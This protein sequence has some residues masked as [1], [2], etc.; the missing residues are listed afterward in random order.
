MTCQGAQANDW[1]L[2]DSNTH[3]EGHASCDDSAAARLFCPIRGESNS[4][5]TIST[6]QACATVVAQDW[7]EHGY[8]LFGEIRWGPTATCQANESTIEGYR[9]WFV[10]ACGVKLNLVGS[11]GTRQQEWQS[12]MM[13]CCHPSWYSLDLGEI[14]MPEATVGLT[15][16]PY[17][18]GTDLPGPVLPIFRR[19]LTTT[20]T[21]TSFTLTTTTTVSISTSSTT[22]SSSTITTT[23]GAATLDGCWG[24][25]VSD[26]ATAADTPEFQEA[27]RQVLARA[28][29]PDVLPEYVVDL[30]LAAG[31]GCDGRLLSGRRLQQSLRVD[32]LI[33]FPTSLGLEA[34][35]VLAETSQK[36]LETV[37]VE[38]TSAWLNEEVAQVEALQNLEVA[39]A[40]KS[41]ALSLSS[42]AQQL[43]PEN[44]ADG[45]A[46]RLTVGSVA[47]LFPACLLVLSWRCGKR[48]VRN[49]AISQSSDFKLAVEVYPE[50]DIQDIRRSSLMDDEDFRLSG[51]VE[52]TANQD[53]ECPAPAIK[54]KRL[55]PKGR[56]A[57][58]AMAITVLAEGA[59]ERRQKAKRLVPKQRKA[60]K[61]P[62]AIADATEPSE[63]Q[64]SFEPASQSGISRFDDD[65][66]LEPPSSWLTDEE[67]ED[68]AISNV[69]EQPSPSEREVST[70]VNA[71]SAPPK[72]KKVKKRAVSKKSKKATASAEEAR[73]EGSE[74]EVVSAPSL[75]W[76]EFQD[77]AVNARAQVA[78]KDDPHETW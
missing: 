41:V 67:E 15:I 33:V 19:V 68:M 5:E 32:Y 47:I 55:V 9:V 31:L 69:L 44:N 22:I 52:E 50:V 74:E 42:E 43:M 11:V 1:C 8:K 3:P 46:I 72:P 30:N 60:K 4:D 10:D 13:E 71:E 17:Q 14:A 27:L 65:G 58:K 77:S 48:L 59:S 37:S 70:R 49:A 16:L 54:P 20:T 39:V 57:K 73:F 76:E 12:E 38:A 40:T 21:S 18:G 36:G 66:L 26:A 62:E 7:D 45:T 51:G 25:S 64:I 34:A 6:C 35:V 24:L 29:G 61:Q 23:P 78:N 56:I 75:P 53:L 2:A 63:I 28:A